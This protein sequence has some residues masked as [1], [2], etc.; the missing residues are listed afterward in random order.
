MAWYKSLSIFALAS[1]FNFDFESFEKGVKE[2]PLR[3]C[4]SSN[5]YTFG[6]V[7]HVMGSEMLVHKVEHCIAVKA[8]KEVRVVNSTV[9]NQ[10]LAKK[11]TEIEAKECRKVGRKEK[12]DYKDELL[13]SMRA[14]ANTKQDFIECYID[15]KARILVINATN[16][17]MIELLHKALM[18]ANQGS[19]PIVPLAPG[20]SPS[21]VM[22]EWLL[23]N[24]IPGA[25]ETGDYVKVYDN[26]E[27]NPSIE[28]KKLEPLSD[29]VTRHLG[30]G[31]GVQALKLRY[32]DRMTF[33]LNDR[34]TITKLKFDD[35]LKEQAFND[36]E[37]GAASDMDAT[38]SIMTL[39]I[40]DFF[41][42]LMGWFEITNP[43]Q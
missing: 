10:L 19:F 28:F 41:G 6:F 39:Q 22:T 8:A 1:D 32:Y 16:D 25:M 12:A 34:L 14:T 35:V 24:S 42:S 33:V 43:A 38:F 26:S 20:S 29:D 2:N 15:L 5:E 17:G 37:G 23:K 13:H 7:P 18:E 31:M 9:L 30:Q 3:N 40:R 36:S 27:D 11:V 21:L 4:N